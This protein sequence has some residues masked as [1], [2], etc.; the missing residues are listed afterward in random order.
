MV[1]QGLGLGLSMQ[2]VQFS[3]WSGSWDPTC[4]VARTSKH[5]MEGKL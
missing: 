1:V 4:L 2:G 3:P 5:K